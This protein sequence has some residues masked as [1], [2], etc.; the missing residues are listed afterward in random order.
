MGPFKSYQKWK[1]KRIPK[2]FRQLELKI[3]GPI[4]EQ[5]AKVEWSCKISSVPIWCSMIKP[6][7][8]KYLKDMDRWNQ[9][10]MILWLF[11][12]TRLQTIYLLSLVCSALYMI[13]WHNIACKL[14]DWFNNRLSDCPIQSIHFQRLLENDTSFFMTSLITWRC[15]PYRIT[16]VPIIS[17]WITRTPAKITDDQCMDLQMSEPDQQATHNLS[18]AEFRAIR[19]KSGGQLPRYMVC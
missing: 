15:W 13:G 10:R 2:T 14:R 6:Y 7:G 11:I 17:N 12:L 3:K 9:A 8:A 5:C 4:S 18:E 1:E 16:A 19:S